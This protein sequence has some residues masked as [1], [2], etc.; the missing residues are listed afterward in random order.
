MTTAVISAPRRPRRAATA[1]DYPSYPGVGLVA[2]VMVTP[3]AVRLVPDAFDAPWAMLPSAL[4]MSLGLVLPV[5]LAATRNFRAF[6]RADH[7]IILGLVYWI[8]LDLIQGINEP[9]GVARQSVEGAY[10]CIGLFACGV[11]V[12]CLLPAP[13]LPRVVYDAANTPLAPRTVLA[14]LLFCF[15]VGMI[16]YLASCDFDIYLMFSYLGSGRFNLP[17][18]TTRLGDWRSFQSHLTYFGHIVPT[19]TAVLGYQIG[20]T[21]PATVIGFACSVIILLFLSSTGTRFEFGSVCGAAVLTWFMIQPKLDRT[22]VIK[23][24][25]VMVAILIWMQVMLYVRSAGLAALFDPTR[26]DVQFSSRLRVDDNFYRISQVVDLIPEAYPYTYG[27]QIYYTLARPIPRALWPDK[28]INSGFSFEE[29]VGIQDVNFNLSITALAEF[30]MDFGYI[31]VGAGG[32]LF[33]LLAA[34][35]NRLLT[36]GRGPARPLMYGLGLLALFTGLR[37]QSMLIIKSY[38]IIAWL[39]IY[40]FALRGRRLLRPV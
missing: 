25:A 23:F 34:M 20:W 32:L 17:W 11:W 40:M 39:G 1:A 19:L 4:C 22:T 13:R 16:H 31:A 7:I 18:G 38:P 28:P 5:V 26:A 12:A 6:L 27:G 3:L 33:G 24:A 21:R 29:A 35:W 37:A 10:W 30:Y 14:V 8:L 2:A 36:E 15:A 9:H